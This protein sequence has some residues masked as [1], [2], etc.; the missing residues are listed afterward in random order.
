MT[1]PTIPKQITLKHYIIDVILLL[2]CGAWLIKTF[3]IVGSPFWIECAD[4]TEFVMGQFNRTQ[5]VS[6]YKD[7]GFTL[8][9]TSGV[10]ERF[11]ADI[12]GPTFAWK[13]VLC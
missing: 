4:E 10:I 5:F 13:C 2:L 8:K 1:V 12:Q 7:C 3:C 11:S 9:G 6:C